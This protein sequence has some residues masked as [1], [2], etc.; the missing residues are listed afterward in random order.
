MSDSALIDKNYASSRERY[1]GLGIDT[2]KALA[3]LGRIPI[4]LLCR[5]EADAGRGKVSEL[6]EDLHEAFRHIPA[7]HRLG[8][9]AVHAESAEGPPERNALEPSH[10]RGWIEW[11]KQEALK[12]DFAAACY[13]HP[14]AASGFTL[15]HQEK[16]VRRFW[17]EHVRRSRRIGA[18][19]GRELKTPCIHALFIPDGS[20]GNAPFDRWARR[21]RLRESLDEIFEAE[22]SPSQVKDALE[23]RPAGDETSPVASLDF[24]LGYAMSRGKLLSLSLGRSL[25]AASAA[26]RISALLQFS[27]EVLVRLSGDVSWEDARAGLPDDGALALAREI[28]RGGASDR[29]HIG[30]EDPGAGPFRAGAWAAGGRAMLKTLLVALLEHQAGPLGPEEKDDTRRRAFEEGLRGLPF[31]A[32]WDQ[33]C[34]RSGVPPSAKWRPEVAGYEKRKGARKP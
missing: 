4:S 28:I 20:A 26:D 18:F 23:I 27:D 11:A 25:S 16:E 22:H 14:L 30:L 31:G 24:C 6:R 1:A 8:L 7:R 29:V 17:I 32:V 15:S 34:L 19:I 12:L 9:C 5:P 10:F 33:H 13:G 3:A 2:E 21:E